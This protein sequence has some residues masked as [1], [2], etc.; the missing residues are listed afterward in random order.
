MF[1]PIKFSSLTGQLFSNIEE[2]NTE[3]VQ[4]AIVP[5]STKIEQTIYKDLLTTSQQALYYAK[6]NTNGLMRGNMAA[7]STYY[8]NGRNDGWLFQRHK[9]A[10]EDMDKIDPA[11]GGDEYAVNGNMIPLSAIPQNLPKGAAK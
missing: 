4:E 11:K 9:R 5:Q 10:L 3:F 6:F 2:M 7:R 8:H 1:R